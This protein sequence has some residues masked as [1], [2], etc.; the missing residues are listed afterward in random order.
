VL[1]EAGDSVQRVILTRMLLRS[2][3]FAALLVALGFI[4]IRALVTRSDVGVFEYVVGAMILVA[5]VLAL[6]RLSRRATH[7][8]RERRERS[9]FF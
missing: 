8:A 7:L 9:R 1:G 6:F 4:L 2:A 3:L 5:L